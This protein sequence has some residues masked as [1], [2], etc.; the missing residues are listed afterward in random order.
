MAQSASKKAQHEG[1]LTAKKHPVAKN[2]NKHQGKTQAG[3]TIADVNSCNRTEATSTSTTNTTSSCSNASASESFPSCSN[4]PSSGRG[5]GGSGE[6]SSDSSSD[7]RE[8][9]RLM[10]DSCTHELA[11]LLR[12][13]CL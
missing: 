11:A 2:V 13:C 4:A 8:A 6:E 10:F 5:P 9:G 3:V 1:K 7:P 12:Y